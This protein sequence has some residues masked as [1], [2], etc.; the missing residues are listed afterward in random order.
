MAGI[1][2]ITVAFTDNAVLIVAIA[3]VPFA[4]TGVVDV[5]GSGNRYCWC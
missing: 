5:A 3:V 1:A 2:V 4:V